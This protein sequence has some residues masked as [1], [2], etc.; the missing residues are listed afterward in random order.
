MRSPP[1][2]NLIARLE[3]QYNLQFS[4]FHIEILE[5]IPS[6][7]GLGSK[8]QFLLGIVKGLCHLKDLNSPLEEL[9]SIVK[10]GGTSGN[11]S[12]CV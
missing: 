8:T 5:S 10:R 7:I 12:A 4:N 6:H 11:R 1:Y 9:I 2:S 3:T